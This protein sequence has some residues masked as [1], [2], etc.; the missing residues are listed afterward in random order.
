MRARAGHA[1]I[2][3]NGLVECGGN[4]KEP[5]GLELGWPGPFTL[6]DAAGEVG[7]VFEE[8]KKIFA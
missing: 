6:A 5:R 7:K 2:F 1:I 8:G 4:V 3:R